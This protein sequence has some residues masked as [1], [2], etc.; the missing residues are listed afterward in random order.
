MLKAIVAP[1]TSLGLVIS[2]L[3]YLGNENVSE[4]TIKII[5]NRLTKKEFHE[6]V[7]A[8]HHM[9]AWMAGPLLPQTLLDSQQPKTLPRHHNI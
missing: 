6:I 3:W 2:A 5:K 1:G 9:P 8:T 4:N 7:K